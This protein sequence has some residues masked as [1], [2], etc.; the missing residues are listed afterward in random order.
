MMIVSE[1]VTHLLTLPQ[2]K[3]IVCQ[4]VGTKMER[5]VESL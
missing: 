4:V 5:S 1:L 3:S 2:C